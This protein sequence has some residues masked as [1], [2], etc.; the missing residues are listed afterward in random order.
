LQLDR[1]ADVRLR[2]DADA[3]YILRGP[4]QAGKTTLLKQALQNA[5]ASG[6]PA[7][8]LLYLSCDRQSA[9]GLQETFM[10]FQVE[11]VQPRAASLWR[12]DLDRAYTAGSSLGGLIAYRLAFAYP[13]VYRGAASLSGAFWPGQDTGTAMRDVLA[14]SGP[15]PIA[16][17]LDHGGTA[18]GGGD[19]YQDSI[20]L[21]D[22]LIAA[23]WTRADSPDCAAAPLALCYFHDAGATHD[24]LA[25]RDRS[26]RFLRYFFDK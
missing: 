23:G 7:T 20:E 8:D 12:I 5:A 22:L 2:F 18:E 17:Y 11:V 10:A 14:A 24:E 15:R 26:W 3:I 19:G 16:L 13:E 21:R 4:R 9:D 1:S 25:W 6:L